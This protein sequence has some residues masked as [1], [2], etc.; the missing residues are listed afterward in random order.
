MILR[1]ILSD[2]LN[3]SISSLYDIDP[4]SDLIKIS[5]VWDQATFVKHHKK[6]LVL[7]FSSMRH[8]SE[9]LKSKGFKV[10]YTKLDDSSKPISLFSELKKEI[11]DSGIKKVIVTEPSEYRL[12]K[13]IKSWESRLG[14]PVEIRPDDRFYCTHEDFNNWASDRKQLRLEYFYRMMRKENNILMNGE[15]PEGGAWNYDVE[16]R[17]VP[18]K[19]VKIPKCYKRDLDQT[20]I[21]VM[22][23]VEQ[24]FP[25]HFGDLEP[26][27]FAVTREQALEALE[28]FIN[29]NLP[30]FGVY[31]DAMLEGE[32]WM[33]HSHLSFYL[34]CGLLLPH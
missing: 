32:T 17:K 8:F 16:N 23:M 9:E 31:Q 21:K 19:S 29:I 20:T 11:Q 34:N 4:K 27:H 12:L 24:M 25:E 26:F 5:E 28:H 6:K 14:I 18:D 3:E 30:S 2:Q 13:E 1:L 33:F 22:S 10:H 15:N 7:I